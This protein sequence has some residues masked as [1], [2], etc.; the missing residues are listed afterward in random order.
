MNTGKIFQKRK[1]DFVCEHCGARVVGDGYTNHCPQCLYS[2]H[3]D[4]FP[5]DRQEA[6]GG[7]MEPIGYEKEKNQE[8]LSYRCVRCGKKGKNKVQEE[9][10]FE[11]I[12][13]VA[14]K[15]AT[16]V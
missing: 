4:V 6:C 12:L 16:T 7:L 11:A 8:R 5:G 13:A 9:D 1:E 3:V 2:K 14:R 10:D 15:R